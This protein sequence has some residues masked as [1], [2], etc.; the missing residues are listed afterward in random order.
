MQKLY[1]VL[2]IF[3]H[4]PYAFWLL[5]LVALVL[6]SG[7]T[8]TGGLYADDYVHKS[9]FLGSELLA[10]KGL[11]DGIGVGNFTELLSDQF[12]FFDPEEDNYA[13]MMKFGMLPWWA[14]QDALL[15]FFRPLTTITHY[16]DY[17]LWPENTH[18]MHGVSL[19]W[20]LLGVLAIYAVYR[21]VGVEKPVALLALLLLILDHSMFQVVTWIASRSMLMVIAFGFFAVYAYHRSISSRSWYVVAF[22]ALLLAALS[23]EAVIGICA[24]LGAYMFTLD[25]RS[26]LKRIM[27]L[28]PFAVLIVAWQF[29]YQSQGYG[30]YGVDFYLD[31]G[32]EPALFLQTALYRLP[33]NFFELV[34][35]I[36]I[37]SGQV[38]FDIRQGF[39][40]L[41]LG[42]ALAIL[43]LIWPLLKKQR[44]MQFFLLGSVFSLIPGLTIAL[45][46]RVMILPFAGFAVV[47]AYIMYFA[48][49]QAFSGVKRVL[50]Y[51]LC[52]YILFA[53]ILLS[54]GLAGLTVYNSLTSPTPDRPYGYVNLGVSDIA[55]KPV[56]V[57]NAFRPFW[58]AFYAHYMASEGEALP[59][60]LRVITS[61]FYPMTVTRVSESELLL[62]ADPAFQFDA[63]SITDLPGRATGHYAYLTQHLM[64]L[65]RGSRDAWHTGET[66]VLPEMTITVNSLFKGK[67]NSLTVQLTRADLADYRW[68][69]WNKKQQ[70]YEGFILPAVGDSVAIE[71]IFDRQGY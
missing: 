11:L 27:H 32:H 71:G 14:S 45:A 9:Y 40:I 34:S 39:A 31:P 35:G 37:V 23:A 59:A 28:L 36:D 38:R 12:N 19:L 57:I 24:Y 70:A 56:V 58:L 10:A 17:Q 62:T 50:A 41:G 20:Y 25:Q 7:T 15:H 26:W 68:S 6:H 51:T 48:A 61:A 67:P 43:W 29:Y 2:D 16:I 22:I 18:M 55:E 49:Q 21:G 30:A 44:A 66:F 54:A 63:T 60:S 65:I 69:Y 52:G 47:L 53:H 4:K 42:S 64:G 3:A 8:I 33:G 13:P 46:P 1:R 5:M